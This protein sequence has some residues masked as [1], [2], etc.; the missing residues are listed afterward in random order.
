M[1]PLGSSPFSGGENLLRFNNGPAFVHPVTHE[2]VQSGQWYEGS[3]HQPHED[4]ALEAIEDVLT[5]NAELQ[6]TAAQR[7]AREKA[8]AKAQAAANNAAQ[9]ASQATS[10]EGAEVTPDGSAE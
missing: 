10:A 2:V 3:A 6:E 7:K 4:S 5:E 8:E 9:N 1:K